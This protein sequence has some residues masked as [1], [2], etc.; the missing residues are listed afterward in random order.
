MRFVV[1]FLRLVRWGCEEMT[2][3]W[4]PPVIVKEAYNLQ[5]ASLI[6]WSL[7]VKRKCCL[8]SFHSG[9]AL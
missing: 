7:I 1:L 4:K 6:N 5:L 3:L 9:L 2:M 8:L